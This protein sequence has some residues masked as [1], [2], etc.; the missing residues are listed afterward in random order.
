ME[1]LTI[2]NNVED[3]HIE[4][5]ET[6]T[7]RFAGDS[8]DGMQLTGTQFTKTT[9][10]MGNDISTLPDFPA[11]I[12]APAGSLPGVSGFQ[13][14]FSSHDIRTPGDA[15]DVLVAMNP[16]AL[17][18]NLSDLE[19]GGILIVN[20]DAFNEN[21]LKKAAYARNPLEDDSLSGYRVFKLP[22]TTL[23]R[24]ALRDQ[25]KL[26]PKEI[27]RCKNFWAL[28]LMYWLYDRPLEPTQKWIEARF[29][30]GTPEVM[31]ANQTA[32]KAGFAY[33]EAAEIFTTH[34]RV[35]RAAIAPGKYRNITG[36]E[37]TAL[38]CVAASVLAKRPLYYASYPIT[39][40]SDILHELSTRKNFE[41]KTFQAE[42]EIAAVC[43]AIGASFAGHLGLTGTSGPGLALKSEA[44]GLAVMTELPVVIIDVQRGGPSTGLPT[45]TEQADLLQAMYGRN[46]ECPVAIVAAATPADCFTMAVEAFRIATAH[47]LPVI[48]LTD[49]YLANGAEPWKLPK[50]EDLP[51]LD[52]RFET[53]P[54]GFAPYK[55]DP[56]TL[57]RAWAIPGTPGLEH[58]IGGIEK[59]DFT[60]NVSYEPE[61]HM[62]MV[63]TR[64][65]KVNRIADDIPE[66]EVFGEP[67]GRL[68]VI[69]WG[70]TYGAI[71]SAVETAQSKGMSV[72]SAHLRYLNPFPK[73]LGQVLGRFDRILVPELNLGQLAMLLRARYLVPA[74]SYPKVKGQPFKISELTAKINE[75]YED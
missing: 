28:G 29:G 20:E 33:A 24:A 74:I 55:R 54:D 66:L 32:L 56:E 3:K 21:N 23:N 42:D 49:G 35:R 75:V 44:I 68:L 40:A 31:K 6:V 47:M 17:K 13:L 37:A 60:G 50:M 53:D 12:R 38:G 11:E 7:I 36:N 30:K 45:K 4:E 52:V 41:V 22:I 64:Q 5:L 9:A 14:N 61:N 8:G 71:T 65:E 51:K 46:G 58:R 27:D 10:I 26:P 63:L 73:N 70:S 48:F 59:Q 2:L 34:Y 39:P 15:P 67:E 57:A 62:H 19:P 69:G 43:A 25:V 18:V 72:S 1:S 16:A